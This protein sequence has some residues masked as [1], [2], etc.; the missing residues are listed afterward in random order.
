MRRLR[1]GCCSLGNREGR[2]EQSRNEHLRPAWH[3]RDEGS[4]KEWWCAWIVN[5]SGEP[6]REVADEKLEEQIPHGLKPVR[7][8]KKLKT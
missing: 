4:D 3:K 7:D 2:E 1:G 6:S 5:E 8:D